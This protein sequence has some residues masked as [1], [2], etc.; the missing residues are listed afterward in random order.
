MKRIISIALLL[1]LCFTVLCACDS[2]IP[3]APSVP[4]GDFVAEDVSINV[5]YPTAD[6]PE[7]DP[8]QGD[9]VPPATEKAPGITIQGFT[10]LRIPAN[11]TE[12]DVCFENPASNNAYY[13]MFE[14]RL[15]NGEDY[16]TLYASDFVN[17]GKKL[18]SITLSRVLEVG[19]YEAVLVVQPY[20]MKDVTPTNNAELCIKL[21]VE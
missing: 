6:T 10:K 3:A 8:N 20:R 5:V 13:F 14:L 9:Y 4:A 12:V 18:E 15:L 16:E 2:D 7:L 19:E 17:P 1:C 21:I 11:Q